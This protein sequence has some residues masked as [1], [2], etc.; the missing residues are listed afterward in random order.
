SSTGFTTDNAHLEATRGP[1]QPAIHILYPIQFHFCPNDESNQRELWYAGNGCVVAQC[2][3]HRL[4]T[5]GF[6][7]RVSF[8]VHP[9]DHAVRLQKDQLSPARA[10]DNGYIIPGPGDDAITL[11]QSR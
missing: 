4:P 10:G 11:G 5:D 7:W 1:G 6:G 9:L 8:K 2:S 3:H